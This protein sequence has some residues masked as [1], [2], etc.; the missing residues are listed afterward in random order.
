MTVCDGIIVIPAFNPD[1]TLPQL[2]A[3]LIDAAVCRSIVIVDDG[4]TTSS[5]RE[6]IRHAETHGATIL[7][8]RENLGKGAA[9]R[10]GIR[11]GIDNGAGFVVTAD[12]DGQHLAH[13][14]NRVARRTAETGQFTIGYR[15]FGPDVPLRSR[16]GNALTTALFRLMLRSPIRDTQS[17]LRGYP[18]DSF[19]ALLQ[20]DSDRYEYEL[21]VLLKLRDQPVEQ[22][23][24]DTVY[25]PGNPSS[26]FRPLVDSARIYFVFLRHTTV[27]LIF[28]L[29]DFI[30]FMLLSLILPLN[31]AFAVVRPLVAIAYF[32]GMRRLVY[33][34][35]GSILWQF[36]QYLILVLFNVFI[37]T[38]VISS[39]M[40]S[41]K[42]PAV[43]FYVATTTVMFFVNFLVQRYLIF[44][45]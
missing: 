43:L 37:A 42:T 16:F 14:I 39:M 5:G 12:A 30:G 41:G 3:E 26:H 36:V 2:V 40:P 31:V 35:H 6:A 22:V 38:A 23:P 9:I 19:D 27:A 45:R 10:T 11:F 18:A 33:H 7:R 20:I 21:D 28:W 4:S 29:I 24:I 34:S 15:E 32:F 8:H 44:R 1:E 25:E 17:G 13:D